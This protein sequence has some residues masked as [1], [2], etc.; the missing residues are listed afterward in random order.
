MSRQNFIP[1]L[2]KITCL[3]FFFYCNNFCFLSK[4]NDDDC[5]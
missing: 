2:A 1:P 4:G 5:V 3:V